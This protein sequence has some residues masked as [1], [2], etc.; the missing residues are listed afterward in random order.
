[1]IILLT[2]LTG[3]K[4]NFS[5]QKR[6]VLALPGQMWQCIVRVAPVYKKPDTKAHVVFRVGLRKKIKI[7][8]YISSKNRKNFDWIE[9]KRTRDG[10]LYYTPFEYFALYQKPVIGN[11][12]YNYKIDR[13]NNIP[14]DYKPNDLKRVPSKYISPYQRKYRYY[15]RRKAL[16][17]FT[18]LLD[19]AKKSGFKIYIA[20]AWRS[21]SVQSYLY[22]RNIKKAGPKQ[23]GSAKPTY[24]EHHLGTTCDFTCKSVGYTLTQRFYNTKEYKWLKKNINKYNMR[25]TYSKETHKQEGY[26][27]EPWHIRYMGEKK[28]TAR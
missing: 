23:I 28:Q 20:S 4:E 26:L 18:K 22:L 1:M 27:W 21:P 5:A 15:L 10:K 24:S 7:T 17:V 6:A 9:F 2:S 16:K 12:A 25:I 11:L 14:F 13:W 8:R 3:I 19:K